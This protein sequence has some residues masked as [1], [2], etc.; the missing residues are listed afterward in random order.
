MLNDGPPLEG[1]RILDPPGDGFDGIRQRRIRIFF[2][3][4]PP[5]DDVPIGRRFG[6][7]EIGDPLIKRTQ[8]GISQA[9]L[10]VV[11]RHLDQAVQ[12]L[13]GD[14]TRVGNR[15]RSVHQRLG[16]MKDVL[17]LNISVQW[18]TPEIQDLALGRI[19]FTHCERATRIG[20]GVPAG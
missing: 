14:I 15:I 18:V 5:V 19:K 1:R 6:R 9:R 7:G 2:H 17:H 11:L 4:M 16:V 8:S 20:I 12:R 10:I 3:Q 13:D